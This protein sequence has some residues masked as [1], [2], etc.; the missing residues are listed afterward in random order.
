MSPAEVSQYFNI[1][2]TNIYKLLSNNKLPAAKIGGR[3]RM[4]KSVLDAW[5]E[6]RIVNQ[7]LKND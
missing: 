3:W 1:S 5:F 4:R 7:R 2:I 6:N